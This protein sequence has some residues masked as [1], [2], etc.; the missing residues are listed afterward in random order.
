MQRYA[1]ADERFDGKTAAAEGGCIVWTGTLVKGGYGQFRLPDGHAMAH[2]YNYERHRG[3]IPDGLVLDH[4]CRNRRCVNP[5]HLEIV[6]TAEN[7]RRGLNG[8]L[9]RN[10]KNGHEMTEENTL[11][12]VN[13]TNGSNVRACRACCREK[14]RRRRSAARAKGG[15]P[16]T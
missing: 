12:Y 8:N 10:C 7:L 6:T 1:N 16:I 2:R 9:F 3:P 15:E 11:R 5:W 4:L 14:M 13:K